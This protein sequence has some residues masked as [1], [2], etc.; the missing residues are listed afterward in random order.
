[1]KI[2]NSK[3]FFIDT[4]NKPIY[5]HGAQIIYE[6]GYYYAYGDHYFPDGARSEGLVAA[7]YLANFL[8]QE[9]LRKKFL[10]GCKKAA[11]S[12]FSLFNC[13]EYIYSHKNQ[14]KIH[15]DELTTK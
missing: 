8:G 13:E 1:M 2:I 4:N 5:A 9:Q 10:E 7:Y 12:Q 3:K 14:T 6:G 15:K 11:K